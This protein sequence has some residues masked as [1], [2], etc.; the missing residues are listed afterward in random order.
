MSQ[1]FPMDA[2]LLCDK[3]AVI[4]DTTERTFTAATKLSSLSPTVTSSKH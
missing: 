2:G 3:A 1:N 4:K